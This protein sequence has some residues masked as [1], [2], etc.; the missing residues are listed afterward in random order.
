MAIAAPRS[1]FMMGGGQVYTMGAQ[2]PF[3]GGIGTHAGQMQATGGYDGSGINP[4]AA[5][6]PVS[7][8][9]PV[10]TTPLQPPS[11]PKQP[12]APPPTFNATAE[13]PMA[14]LSTY[15]PQQKQGS[16]TAPTFQGSAQFEAGSYGAP[17]ISTPTYQAGNTQAQ[18]VSASPASA[19]QFDVS[20]FRPFADAVYSEAT[21]QLDPQFQSQEAA[22]RQRMVN[23]GIQEGTPAF[24]TAL[25]NFERSR[26]DAYSQARNQSLA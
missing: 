4:G 19:G 7:A 25:G 17:T 20:A 13:N 9:T 12:A 21:R 16:Y 10:P 18:Q 8:T 26:N 3:D 22:F 15:Q 11:A 6:P 5:K 14:A 2:Q 24:D 23:Q 1:P